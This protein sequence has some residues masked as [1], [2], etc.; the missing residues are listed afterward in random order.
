[1]KNS[2]R[3]PR[4][5]PALVLPVLTLVIWLGGLSVGVAGFVLPW[6]RPLPPEKA[7]PPVPVPFVKVE[8]TGEP[9]PPA[10]VPPA[11]TVPQPP[12]LARPPELPSPPPLAV[13]APS[14]AIVFAVP[15]PAPARVVPAPEAAFR[16]VESTPVVEPS[17][18]VVPPAPAPQIL[19]FGQGEGRQ[20]LPEYPREARRAGQ[21]GTVTLRMTADEAGRVLAAEVHAS[22]D[23]PL[24]D[25]A[26]L[27][28][29][30]SRWRFSPGP[31]RAYEVAIHFQL[32][33]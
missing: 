25:L 23:W 32:S 22:S 4:E 13:A 1:M 2:A 14:P 30:K 8:L 9:P 11:T 19:T 3:I 12:P 7:S 10:T 16:T 20:P 5:E 21:Q 27:R 29:A 17:A 24:L 6:L 33:K 31:P 18:P 26:A 28:A 15:V